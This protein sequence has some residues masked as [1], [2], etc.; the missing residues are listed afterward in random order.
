VSDGLATV[1]SLRAR[2][3]LFTT[4]LLSGRGLARRLRTGD[5]V[6]LAV[7]PAHVHAVA[8]DDDST[9]DKLA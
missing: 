1:V 8:I 5:R 9:P 6:S 4:H 2:D 3:R 7:D